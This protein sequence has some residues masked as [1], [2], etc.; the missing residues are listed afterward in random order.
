MRRVERSG[1]LSA[2]EALR[3]QFIPVGCALLGLVPVLSLVGAILAPL[4]NVWLLWDP[5]R[6]AL[7]D[8]V[9]DTLVVRVPRQR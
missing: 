5:R 6:Q 7:H 3:R 2:A 4:D 8:K 1:P 9:A